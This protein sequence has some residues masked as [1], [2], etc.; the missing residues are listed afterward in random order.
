MLTNGDIIYQKASG[1]QHTGKVLVELFRQL[2]K[3]V[4][5]AFNFLPVCQLEHNCGNEPIEWSDHDIALGH[6]SA[7]QRECNCKSFGLLT[8]LES[9][10]A[11]LFR[12]IL[13]ISV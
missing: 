4:I 3:D 11:T 12:C 2:D 7:Y 9:I 1:P 13:W 10:K 6:G 5:D 8:S